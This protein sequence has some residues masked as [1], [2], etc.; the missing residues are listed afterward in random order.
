MSRSIADGMYVYTSDVWIVKSNRCAKIRVL[1]YTLETL[2]KL[3]KVSIDLLLDEGE[4]SPIE[5][6]K[7]F[8]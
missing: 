7:G 2:A 8:E 5:L 4:F 6:L 3:D 1:P